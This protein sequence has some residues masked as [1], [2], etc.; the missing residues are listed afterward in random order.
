MLDM[1]GFKEINDTLGHPVGDKTLIEIASR[2]RA[3]FGGRSDVARLGGDETLHHLPATSRPRPGRIDR[4]GY[5]QS[6]D[7]AI[8]NWKKRSSP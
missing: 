6:T 4:R 8:R 3:A 5:L 1:D 7:A 2:L